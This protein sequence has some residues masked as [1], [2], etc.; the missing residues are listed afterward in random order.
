MEQLLL[1]S[2]S[3]SLDLE[4]SWLQFPSRSSTGMESWKHIC[5]D[6]VAKLEYLQLL[7]PMHSRGQFLIINGWLCVVSPNWF[8][9]S[10]LC[11]K[12]TAESQQEKMPPVLSFA[13]E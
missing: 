3:R 12:F 13:T 2:V 11:N 5:V 7:L 10:A 1:H 8:E 9:M 6:T 4:S